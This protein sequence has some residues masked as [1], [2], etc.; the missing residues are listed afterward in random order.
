MH[1]V[2]CLISCF[3]MSCALRLALFLG[4]SLIGFLFSLGCSR[5]AY[6]SLYIISFDKQSYVKIA[7]NQ[8][9]YFVYCCWVFY[10]L[11]F[12]VISYA[13]CLLPYF[14]P[15]FLLHLLPYLLPCLLSCFLSG[16]LSSFH[17]CLDIVDLLIFLSTL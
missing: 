8:Y 17:I 10:I 6:F 4:L 13:L 9:R 16:F 11:R 5:S 2:S 12:C 15:C 3:Y 1:C 7:A 14:L